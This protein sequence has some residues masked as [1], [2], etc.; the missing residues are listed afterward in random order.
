MA[1]STRSSLI[2]SCALECLPLLLPAY[3]SSQLSGANSSR[4][5][6]I[7]SSYTITS[8]RLISLRPFIVMSSYEPHPAPTSAAPGS[9][10]SLLLSRYFCKNAFSSLLLHTLS[11]FMQ[12]SDTSLI[13]AALFLSSS[14]FSL[15][16][17]LTSER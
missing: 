12:N 15:A 1:F 7:R 6:S 9:T 16:S 5:S 3:I 4:C 11:A 17:V 13:Y 14:I 2:S 8:A 10:V